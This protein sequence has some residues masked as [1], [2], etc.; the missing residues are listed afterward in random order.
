MTP[1]K[2]HIYSFTNTTTPMAETINLRLSIGSKKGRAAH[3]ASFV[4]L[5]LE[6]SF[7]GTIGKPPIHGFNVVPSYHQCMRYLVNRE[8]ATI[9]RKQLQSRQLYHRATKMMKPKEN[10]MVWVINE[11]PHNGLEKD[12]TPIEPIEDGNIGG[13][14][15]KLGAKL[16]PKQKEEFCQV[17]AKHNVG[18]MWEGEVPTHLPRNIVCHKLKVEP[19]YPEK[20]QKHRS[21]T[22]KRNVVV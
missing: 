18:F 22:A 1:P 3:T 4:V 17:L 11:A 16:S 7:N 15:I 6:S 9:Y 19:R 2:E 12:E 13:G 20:R 21:L 8:V 14:I 10:Q 5:N